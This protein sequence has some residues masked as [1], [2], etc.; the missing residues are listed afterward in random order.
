MAIGVVEVTATAVSPSA[1]A[2]A[3]DNNLRI[4]SLT[5]AAYDYLMTLPAEYR[6]YKSSNRRSTGL[7]LF[8]LLRYS[9]IMV[10]VVSNVGFFHHGFTSN[11][12]DHY[13]LVTPVFK[14]IQ[15]MT[16]QAILAIRTYG[17]SQRNRWVGWTLLLA[18]TLA[19]GFQWFSSIYGRIPLMIN[20]NCTIASAHPQSPISTWSF[21][22]VAMLFDCLTL[23]ISTFCLVKVRAVTSGSTSQLCRI[24]LYDGLGYFIALTL[25]NAAN[26]VLYRGIHNVIQTTGA[27]F[28]YAVTWIMSQRILIHPRDARTTDQT[29]VVL[30][31]LPS[32]RAVMSALRFNKGTKHQSKVEQGDSLRPGSQDEFGNTESDFDLQVHIDKSIVV[33]ARAQDKGTK[34]E[35]LFWD[36]V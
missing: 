19:A 2:L 34:D 18:Y 7:I 1:G 35:D 23:S 10:L 12:C 3:A 36:R 24:L 31:Q 16:S 33:D 20:G 11:T 22:F 21:Y 14:V 29:S 8:V 30:S 25:T 4:A 28:E 13:Y 32:S 15:M 27:S 6:L 17:I 5:M 26:I 9:S